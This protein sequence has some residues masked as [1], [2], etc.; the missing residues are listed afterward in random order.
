MNQKQAGPDGDKKTSRFV[1]HKDYDSNTI[2][3]DIAL[4][5][6]S[7]DV[8]P[9]ANIAFVDYDDHFVQGGQDVTVYGWGLTVGGGQQ[10]PEELMR[11]HLKTMTNADCHAKWGEVN[12]IADGMLCA[13]DRND[14][15][16][17]TTACNG[18]SGGPLIQVINGKKMLVGLVSWGENGCKATMPNVYTRISTYVDWIK[19]NMQN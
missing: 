15:I 1:M 16:G 19:T 13:F 7:A 3:N 12:A 8:N 5:I 6:L 4:I 17:A 18:D 14:A 10:V 2:K 9:S 11:G